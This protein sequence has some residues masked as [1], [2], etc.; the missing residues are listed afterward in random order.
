MAQTP[1]TQAEIVSINRVQLNQTE[2][3]FEVI[4]LTP[5]GTAQQLQVVNVSAGNNF[6]AEIPNAQLQLPDGQPFRAE[7]PIEGV[8]EVTVTNQNE[9]TVRVTATGE[10]KQPTIE[11]FDS[12]EGLIFSAVGDA[13]SARGEEDIELVVTGE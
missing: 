11:L 4:L 9:N 12:K 13:P 2:T 8:S 3:G 10:D 1:P 5:T 6:I 7:N